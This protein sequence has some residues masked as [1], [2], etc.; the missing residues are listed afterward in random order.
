MTYIER[1]PLLAELFS[2]QDEDVDVMLEFAEFSAADVVKVVRCKE[3]KHRYY[4]E[5]FSR[6]W[7]NRLS[8]T[9]EV[10]ADNFCGYGE[11]RED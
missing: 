2:K 9:F 10:C 3:C 6:L 5:E 8:G 1:E 11:K 4:D 7:C